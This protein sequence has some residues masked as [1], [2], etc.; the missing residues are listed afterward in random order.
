MRPRESIFAAQMVPKWP[1]EASGALLGAKW[2]PGASP[3]VSQ[4]APG[5]PGAEQKTHCYLPGG[6]RRNFPARFHPPRGSRGALWAPFWEP[7]GLILALRLA[8]GVENAKMSILIASRPP[9]ATRGLRPRGLR[10]FK[11]RASKPAKTKNDHEHASEDER[12]L[13][14]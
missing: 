10:T 4:N 2:A 7:L 12:Q 13:L 8:T 11:M 1:L 5:P 6:L 14:K 3:G 9:A